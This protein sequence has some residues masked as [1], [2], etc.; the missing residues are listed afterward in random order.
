MNSENKIIEFDFNIVI[1]GFLQNLFT[2]GAIF[3]LVLCFWLN[4]YL[5]SPKI[6]EVK[7]L[8]QIKPF[9]SK[10]SEIENLLMGSER[11]QLDEQIELYKSRSNFLNV[12]DNLS[13]NIFINGE[14]SS[15]AL[16]QY[17]GI[18]V[19]K[20]VPIDEL[21]LESVKDSFNFYLEANQ[22]N[23]NLY[24]SSQN[25]IA[26]NVAYSSDLVVDNFLFVI[27]EP[28][29]NSQE[30]ISIQYFDPGYIADYLRSSISVTKL[31]N[32]RFSYFDTSLLEVSFPSDNVNLSMDTLNTANNVFIEKS[33]KENSEEAR[34]SIF[35]LNSQ[36]DKFKETYDQNIQLLNEYK[37][38]YSTIDFESEVKILLEQ[39]QELLS[40]VNALELRQAEYKSLYR[41]GNPLLSKIADQL[42]ELENK[43]KAISNEITSLPEIQK[44]YL[45]LVREF[46]IS[47]T[48]YNQL[49]ERSVELSISEASTLGNVKIVDDAYI[50]SKISPRGLPSLIQSLL[51][52]FVLSCIF[53]FI[54]MRYFQKI[55]LPSE[56]TESMPNA[57]IVGTIGVIED[58]NMPLETEGESANV[59][60]TN[61]L[62]I[63]EQDSLE[64]NVNLICGPLSSIGKTTVADVISKSL[65][66]RGIKTVLIDLDLKKGS[67]HKIYGE[68]IR[69][70]HNAYFEDNFNLEPHKI[71]ENLYVIGR[72]KKSIDS[73]QRIFESP[74]FRKFIENLSLKFDQVI[75]D[76]A[77]LLMTS[78]TLSLLN[79]ESTKLCVLKHNESR[80]K[81]IEQINDLLKLS[82]QEIQYFVYNYFS[83]PRGAYGYYYDRYSYNY[84]SYK[85]AYY[86][87]K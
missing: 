23:Y 9:Q 43:R 80:L 85:S 6:Y 59:L 67:L 45:D 66:S 77:P 47:Q 69:I 73:V 79:L 55:Q 82:G 1:K 49:L 11:I 65:V 25:K 34:A 33:V 41:P 78:D 70:N 60:V 39:E 36:I 71:N 75:I 68:K 12:V 54:R 53:V 17:T 21:P 14:M 7:S 83:R 10:T 3:F 46:E 29:E 64:T 56:V 42:A 18:S 40:Q 51:I 22:D 2:I 57:N 20:L 19:S 32:T 86:D 8:I 38:E 28:K 62:A 81:D 84:Y 15:G 50:G 26:E 24:D 35:Y 63:Q 52:A 58:I 31:I 74:K 16:D 76:S 61:L 48:I 4:Y 5:Y 44:N 87:E 27:T 72:P 30:L 37:E 13:L